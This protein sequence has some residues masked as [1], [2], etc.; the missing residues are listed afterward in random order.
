MPIN[1]H[2][3]GPN[4][5]QDCPPGCPQPAIDPARSPQ[6]IRL[7]FGPASHEIQKSHRQIRLVTRCSAFIKKPSPCKFSRR[8]VGPP[9]KKRIIGIDGAKARSG[10]KRSTRHPT[11]ATEP[12]SSHETV[13]NCARLE[14][15]E[16]TKYE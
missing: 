6:H 16:L 8:N 1:Q 7:G 10:V 15:A 3:K 4:D 12:G 9:H 5:F 2:K 13:L 11:P 14:F